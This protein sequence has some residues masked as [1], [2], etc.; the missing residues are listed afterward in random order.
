MRKILVA[1]DNPASR[2]LL[3]EILVAHGYEVAE[4]SNGQEALEKIAD[5]RPDLVLLDIQMPILD[6][7]SVVRRLRQDPRFARLRVVALTAYAM[8]GDRERALAAGFD[9]YIT[10]P[11]T[12]AAI[13]AQIER[14]LGPETRAPSQSG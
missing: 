11:V 13:R 1:E 2:E 9:A 3:R 12:V 4:V 7:F 14:F 6:G 5:T 10:K 8:R